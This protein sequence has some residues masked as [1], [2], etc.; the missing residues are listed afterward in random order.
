[1]RIILCLN[2]GGVCED[3]KVWEC[4]GER[5]QGNEM[6]SRN[7]RQVIRDEGGACATLKF[8]SACVFSSCEGRC[9]C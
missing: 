9:D 8:V 1:M 3:V 2:S 4:D 5:K 6:S 7:R